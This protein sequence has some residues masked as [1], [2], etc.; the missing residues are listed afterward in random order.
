MNNPE[1]SI[2]IPTYN[3]AEVLIRAI[4]SSLKQSYQNWE[5]IIIDDCSTDITKE[6]ISLWIA[7]DQVWLNR[8]VHYYQFDKNSGSPVKPRNYG[9][10]K[11][12][13]K[14]IAFLDSDDAWLPNKLE[15]QLWYMKYHNSQ[16]TYHNMKVT[17]NQEWSKM[18]TCH[19]DHVF[20]FLLRK[21]FIPTSSV[22]MKK[23]LY[24]KYGGMNGNLTI[25]HDWDL[26]LK[27]AYD[28]PVHFINE[29]LGKLEIH[30]GSI[31]SQNHKRRVD[32]RKI[33]RKWKDKVDLRYYR[34]IMLY[35]YLME[36]YD[37]LPARIQNIIRE[38]WYNQ[39]KYKG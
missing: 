36:V 38:A 10:S 13:G 1:I 32:S 23:E 28:L 31:I 4:E 8:R 20:K 14:Y 29:Q 17:M 5:I 11:A 9:V 2:I 15:T 16:F 21:N 35:Y 24:E 25:N 22:M 30:K 39:N 3:R 33:I 18:S 34:K 12:K 19:S 27:I 26:W 6:T 7:K 37:I